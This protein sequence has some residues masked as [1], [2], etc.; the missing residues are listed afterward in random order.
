MKPSFASSFSAEC[1]GTMS[2]SSGL[3]VP[4]AVGV[5]TAPPSSCLEL[6]PVRAE[7][8]VIRYRCIEAANA[9][10]VGASEAIASTLQVIAQPQGSRTGKNAPKHGAMNHTSLRCLSMGRDQILGSYPT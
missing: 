10:F 1:V 6:A 9:D 8:R 5:P 2:C 7:R 3:A 4:A